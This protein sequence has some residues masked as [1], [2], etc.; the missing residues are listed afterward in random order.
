MT[1]DFDLS[2]EEMDV[3]GARGKGD[4]DCRVLGAMPPFRP[5]TASLQ[6]AS[7]SDSAL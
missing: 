7:R 2:G 4:T 1:Y 3:S 5:S 6:D